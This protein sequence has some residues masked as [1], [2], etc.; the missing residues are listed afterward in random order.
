[1]WFIISLVVGFLYIAGTLTIAWLAYRIYEE[2]DD[3]PPVKELVFT[4]IFWPL[5]IIRDIYRNYRK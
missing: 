4:L 5:L 1:M 3:L 2:E